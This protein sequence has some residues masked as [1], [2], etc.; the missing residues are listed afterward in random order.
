MKKLLVFIGIFF[1]GGCLVRTYT[2]DQPRVDTDIQGNR[3]Y[4]MGS[5]S[6]EQ[7]DTIAKT[8]R[9]VKVV[10]V[11][12]GS[13][14]P[15]KYESKKEGELEEADESTY[16][17]SEYD[18]EEEVVTPDELA[19]Q[20]ETKKIEENKFESYTIQKNDTL[21]KISQKFYGTTKKWEFIYLNNKDVL[22]SPDSIHPGHV[23]KIPSLE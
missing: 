9:K 14:R 15:K 20:E 8:T 3:G 7:P 16:P 1:L 19:A 18:N 13:H 17:E 22:K 11:E 5:G 2:V 21:Q 6:G 23:I 12:L 10:E 4:L